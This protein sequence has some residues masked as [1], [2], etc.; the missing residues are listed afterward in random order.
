M[1]ISTARKTEINRLV[2]SLLKER[3]GIDAHL[4]PETQ[5]RI[6]KVLMAEKSPAEE[7]AQARLIT[8]ILQEQNCSQD[9]IEYALQ[10]LSEGVN[11]PDGYRAPGSQTFTE[12]IK[13]EI[14]YRLNDP[15]DPTAAVIDYL[16]ARI[17]HQAGL[18]PDLADALAWS[19]DHRKR[20]R[21]GWAALQDYQRLSADLKNLADSEENAQVRA[22]LQAQRDELWEKARRTDE[23]NEK[24]WR[25]L[26]PPG[27][28]IEREIADQIRAAI[29]TPAEYARLQRE[30]NVNS[31]LA[32]LAKL[33]PRPEVDVG[34]IK[35]F[36]RAPGQK[37]FIAFG[38]DRK[39]EFKH[40]TSVNV[41]ELDNLLPVIREYLLENSFFSISS[42]YR[43]AY[44][45]DKKS[46]L[47]AVERS[48]KSI[49][50]LNAC[51]VDLDVG[52]MND[53]NPA[54][55]LTWGD[56]VGAV[57]N[58]ADRGQIP[59]PSVIARS[60]R[61]VYVFWLLRHY[62]F[63]DRPPT[64]HS[65]ELALFDKIQNILCHDFIS[66]AADVQAKDACRFF[67]V[68]GSRNVKAGAIVRYLGLFTDQNVIPVYTLEDLA[69]WFGVQTI[70]TRL[71]DETEIVLLPA[72]EQRRLRPVI[73]RGSAPRRRAG[74]QKRSANL[75]A[76]LLALADHFG[77]WQQGQRYDRLRLYGQL[78][79]NSGANLREVIVGV[80]EM[81]AA[82]RPPY[83]TPGEA[84]DICPTRIVGEIFKQRFR[85]PPAAGKL[86]KTLSV[87]PDLARTLKLKTIVPAEI[88]EER[89][90]ITTTARERVSERRVFIW[91]FIQQR[92]AGRV[93]RVR[94]LCKVLQIAGFPASLGTVIA[95]LKALNVPR[96]RKWRKRNG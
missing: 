26:V 14:T 55:R 38:L 88:I 11:L 65:R 87:T 51:F 84:N 61:G 90:A 1:T 62:S 6:G 40:Y 8:R 66:L 28:K 59:P 31:V 21:E 44:W 81:A 46:G 16:T 68:P 64:G 76:D 60:G 54:R 36:H 32:R 30:G 34:M 91:N 94:E 71:P 93:P 83:P 67:R 9:E 37:V 73:D 57:L 10:L 12:I 7:K 95:D 53:Q 4:I 82:C 15:N 25:R 58:M 20:E 74:F 86:V 70:K 49:S 77:G 50:A 45:T 47:P 79:F 41:S 2:F 3:F 19:E 52:R 27:S 56:A 63:P 75:A 92:R 29:I 5:F 78:L 18:F 48:K 22:A 43:A 69:E 23:E 24:E 17:I 33:P 96:G 85:N 89:K 13:A 42:F 72:R 80:S 39:G 35:V